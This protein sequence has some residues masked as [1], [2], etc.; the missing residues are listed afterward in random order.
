MSLS[1][2]KEVSRRIMRAALAA[3]DPA[4]AVR[5]KI[6]AAEHGFNACGKDYRCD[7]RLLLVAAGKAAAGMAD[8]ALEILG[9]RVSEGI[10]VTPRGYPRRGLPH[11]RVTDIEAGHPV[12]NQQGHDAARSV[13]ELADHMRESDLLLLLLSGGGSSLLPFPHPPL[14]L[15]DKMDTTALLLKCGASIRELNTVRTHMSAIKG[16]RLAARTRGTIV[17]LAI[18]D[19]VGDEIAFISSGPAVPD[20]TTFADA[21]AVLARY[22][23]VDKVPSPVRAL[24][25]E[26][27]AGRVPDTPKAIPGRFAASIVASSGLAV[28]AAVEEAR[29][30]GFAGIVLTTFLQG[31]A[32]AAG[33]LMASVARE[34]RLHGRPAPP[35]VCIF[36][37]G[38]TTVTVSGSG[39]GGRNQ[40]IALA[41]GIDFRGE[42]GVLLASFATDGRDGNTDA[43]GAYA[44]GETFA[45]GRREGLDPHAC[46]AA[47]DAHAFLSAAGDLIVT[48][49]TG[50]NVNDI[51]FVLI[52]K[53]QT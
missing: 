38:E 19:I 5:A 17:T 26:G 7:G 36:A 4:A 33:R 6:A 45:A 15:R 18:S 34:V 14:T 3:A 35:P 11:P 9:A 12:P 13:V 28:D 37:A 24:I 10:V 39:K 43:A 50:T 22:G 32:R 31:E 2:L 29:A 27:V 44:S 42:T 51:T 48:G 16:G 40:E 20:P 41:A 53:G 8:A 21:A 25:A 49:P 30:Q 46:L 23:L 1:E 52:E 47:N